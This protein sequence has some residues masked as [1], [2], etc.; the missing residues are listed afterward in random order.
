MKCNRHALQYSN[1]TNNLSLKS[2]LLQTNAVYVSYISS[3]I[4]VNSLKSTF[5]VRYRNKIKHLEVT[6]N[7]SG[8]AFI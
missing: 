8:V 2:I 4:L 6:S 7:H 1:T 5:V 3:S